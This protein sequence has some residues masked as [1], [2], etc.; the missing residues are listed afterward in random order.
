MTDDV[1]DY[2]NLL[3]R[4]SHIIYNHHRKTL[5]IPVVFSGRETW[6]LTL[7]G[8]YTLRVFPKNIWTYYEGSGGR[9]ENTA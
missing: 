6:S 9:L 5:I 8:I 3:V 7:K 1:R 2:M 4:I